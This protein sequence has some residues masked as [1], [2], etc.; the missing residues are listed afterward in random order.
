MTQE[1]KL[2]NGYGLSYDNGLKQAVIASLPVFRTLYVDL[3]SS[4]AVPD[5]SPQRPFVTIGAA[6]ATV[7]TRGANLEQITHIL[8]APGNYDEDIVFDETDRSVYLVSG[9]GFALGVPGTSV[10][11]ITLTGDGTNDPLFCL[12]CGTATKQAPAVLT[13]AITS[14]TNNGSG[15][16]FVNGVAIS[17][18]AATGESITHSGSMVMLLTTIGTLCASAINAPLAT[19]YGAQTAIGPGNSAITA[20]AE[21]DGGAVLGNVALGTIA[22]APGGWTNVGFSGAVTITAATPSPDSLVWDALTFANALKDGVTITAPLR[23]RLLGAASF[24]GSVKLAPLGG[25]MSWTSGT[26]LQVADAVL[27]ATEGT[28]YNISLPAGTLDLTTVGPGGLDAGTLAAAAVYYVYISQGVAGACLFAT[29]SITWG[30]ADFS[31]LTGYTDSGARIG[32]FHT[33]GSVVP[34]FVQVGSGADRTY[35][36]YTFGTSVGY[37]ATTAFQ[38]LNCSAFLPVTATN[39]QLVAQLG[40]NAAATEAT[41]TTSYDGSSSPIGLETASLGGGLPVAATLAGNLQAPISIPVQQ[42]NPTAAFYYKRSA[43]AAA[44]ACGFLFTGYAETL[45]P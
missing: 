13:G 2:A 32:S 45:Q 36:Y 34:K 41:L 22:S 12:D 25:R 42:G 44:A 11:N 1:L 5:G 29:T 19:L 27:Q 20:I 6:L 24:D 38:A 30:A 14:T 39:I 21:M 8:V 26:Q 9:P 31:A 17:D 15:F 28:P 35:Y 3:S 18:G 16:L 10:R 7:A 43:G 33:M 37:A 40:Y 23:P 4:A